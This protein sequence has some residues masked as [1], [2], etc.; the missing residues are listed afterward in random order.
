MCGKDV[1]AGLVPWYCSPL[2]QYDPIFNLTLVTFTAVLDVRISF[3]SLAQ[4]ILVVE[5]WYCDS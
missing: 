3:P 1:G 4:L 2:R 5:F